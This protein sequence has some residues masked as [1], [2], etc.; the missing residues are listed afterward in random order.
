MTECLSTDF[1][2]GITSVQRG[3]ISI[4]VESIV[5]DFSDGYVRERCYLRIVDVQSRTGKEGA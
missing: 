4:I 3:Y 2:E 5:V 1:V